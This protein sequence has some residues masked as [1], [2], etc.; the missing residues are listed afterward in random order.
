MHAFLIEFYKIGYETITV[1]IQ[2]TEC[3]PLYKV[4]LT[5]IF[6]AQ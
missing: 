3:Y 5:V 6:R 2:K 1:L 4:A